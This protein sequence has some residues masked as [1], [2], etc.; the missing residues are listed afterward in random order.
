M[1]RRVPLVDWHWDRPSWPR[2]A[3][4]LSDAVELICYRCR[5]C[6]VEWQC[7]NGY[8]L[9]VAH[10]RIAHPDLPPQIT[11]YPLAIMVEP[12]GRDD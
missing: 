9:I 8:D 3:T 4:R 7:H 2:D 5:R 10:S 11:A 6:G 12:K 1:I